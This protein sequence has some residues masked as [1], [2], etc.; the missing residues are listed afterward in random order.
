MTSREPPSLA[1][2]SQEIRERMQAQRQRIAL[3]L[4]PVP[5]ISHR[6]P[7]SLTMRVLIRLLR[8]V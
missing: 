8:Y 1:A 2:Q 3:Q 4:T 6:F 7:R 5:A